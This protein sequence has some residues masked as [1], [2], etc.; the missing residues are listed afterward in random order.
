MAT[1]QMTRNDQKKKK[2]YQ[3]PQ[4][5][6]DDGGRLNHYDRQEQRQ[7]KPTQEAQAIAI[8]NNSIA[9]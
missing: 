9:T 2:I 3:G 1:Y 8:I 7:G 6:K 5:L 4:R